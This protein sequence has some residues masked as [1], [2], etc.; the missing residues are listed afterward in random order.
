MRAEDREGFALQLS[1]YFRSETLLFVAF[2]ATLPIYAPSQLLFNGGFVGV[3]NFM[4][5]LAN[6]ML[7]A[8]VVLGLAAALWSLRQGDAVLLGRPLVMGACAAYVLG[9][10]LLMAATAVEGLATP[11]AGAASGLLLAFGTVVLSVAW[12]AY[13]A[14]FGLREALLW[15]SV[16]V[17]LASLVQLLLSSVVFAVGSIVFVILVVL[18]CLLPAWLAWHGTLAMSAEG[19]VVSADRGCT[20][21]DQGRAVDGRRS[22]GLDAKGERDQGRASDSRSAGCAAKGKR[23]CGTEGS[24]GCEPEGM[25]HRL[26]SLASVV[27][28]PFVGLMVFAFTMG[29]RKFILFDVVHMEVLGCALGAVVVLPICLIRTERPLMPLIYRLLVPLFCLVL[30]VLNAFPASTTPLWLAGWLSYV[31]Y[32]A[33]AILALA[34]LCAAAHASEFP[35]GLIYGLTVSGFAL[36]SIL[37]VAASHLPPFQA[38][39]GGPALLVIST[40]YFAYLLISALLEPW[41]PA[42]DV[43]LIGEKSGGPEATGA[44]GPDVAARCEALADEG[45][46]T[47]REREILG[48][49]GR[50]HGIAFIADTL[51]ISESTVRTHVKAI[52][53]KL[54]VG[55][56]EEL[57]ERVDA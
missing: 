26:R 55:S 12:G 1:R 41:R 4:A 47:P 11:V 19:S 48:Y 28:M 42:K 25:A 52:Y 27:A 46:L 57:L 21:A 44:V 9:Y 13:L 43:G 29:A 7:G 16:M 22:V 14:Q 45:A 39:S 37:G 8:T 54:G 24:H 53:R 51:V 2:L 30:I 32:G 15:L 34:S 3:D 5:P 38:E 20:G 35:S 6:T 18:A 10:G 31:F 17:G 40:L 33:V 36:C 23:A 56:R 50:G 49:L